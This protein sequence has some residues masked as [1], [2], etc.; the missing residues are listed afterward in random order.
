MPTN[1]FTYFYLLLFS[2]IGPLLLS[3]DKKVSFYRDWK[4]FLLSMFPVSVFY[5]LWDIIFTNLNVWKFNP[6]FLIGQYFA[7]IPIEEYVFFII[8]PYCCLFIYACL[9]TYFPVIVYTNY[10]LFFS[11]GLILLSIA[12]IVLHPKQL[13]TVTTFGLLLLSLCYFTL[14]HKTQYLPHTYLSWIIALVPM[15]LVNGVLT[16][17]P[18]LIYTATENMGIR[19]GTIPLEDFFYNL[20]YML[21]MIY[22]YEFW[23]SKKK[24]EL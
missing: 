17:K 4:S 19:I 14:S 21:W 8:I 2:I 9:K 1:T 6:D 10:S 20:I 23:K 22:F 13:Y 7:N 12:I 3:F 15:A 5:I 24:S 11:V 16:G 18:I